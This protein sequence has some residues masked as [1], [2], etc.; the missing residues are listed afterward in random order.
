[1]AKNYTV[2]KTTA[3]SALAMLR[4][5]GTLEHAAHQCSVQLTAIQPYTDSHLIAVQSLL[6]KVAAVSDDAKRERLIGQLA[7]IAS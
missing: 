1:M 3:Q 7:Q 6:R 2:S 5:F 4:M